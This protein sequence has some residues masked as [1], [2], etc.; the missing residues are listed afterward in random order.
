M[1][2]AIRPAFRANSAQRRLR[3]R[4]LRPEAARKA[5]CL[6]EQRQKLPLY[7]GTIRL[8]QSVQRRPEALERADQ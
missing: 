2:G 6:I 3:A 1:V 5:G 8:R 4:L 7:A